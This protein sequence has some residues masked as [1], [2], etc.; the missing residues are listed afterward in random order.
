M[1]SSKPCTCTSEE[2]CSGE[3]MR[4]I[5]PLVPL[6]V[7][8]SMSLLVI[9]LMVSV[10]VTLFPTV[11]LLM[12]RLPLV[13]RGD[14]EDERVHSTLG[15]GIPNTRQVSVTVSDWLATNE[16]GVTVTSEGSNG[17]TEIERVLTYI[18]LPRFV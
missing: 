2:A 16:E 13:V 7:Y 3:L 1:T 11:M 4:F 9:W 8:V 5:R 15:V 6:Q 18:I 17:G 12:V 14:P 10:E